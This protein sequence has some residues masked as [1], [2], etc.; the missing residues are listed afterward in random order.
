[1]IAVAALLLL[2]DPVVAPPPPAPLAASPI[3][4]APPIG[5]TMTY[6]VTNRRLARDGSMANFTLVYALRW[7]R[8]GRGVQL[9]A[10]LRD[11]TS[12]ARPE[13][14]QAFDR[15][16]QPL[17]DQ[18]IT[19]LVA[20]DGSHID[21]VDPEG[22]WQ[23]VLGQTQAMAGAAG[24]AEAKQ[25]ARLLAALSP[26]DRERLATSDIRALIVPANAEI[27]ASAATGVSARQEGGLRT[28]ARTEKSDS[29]AVG[30]QPPIEIDARWT[31]DAATGLLVGERRQSWI[32]GAGEGGRRLVE[33]RI[34][35]VE[36]ADPR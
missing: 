4:F 12:D 5:R 17:V 27:P 6:R 20:P 9:V 35:Q 36:L 15:L 33:E 34:R 29:A 11:V 25:A 8:V 30:A 2:A 22:L 1:M 31:I 19:Y 14:A 32:A 23:R 10:T 3:A 28:I 24:Q 26:A 13:L 18:A 21:L 16:M 7:D